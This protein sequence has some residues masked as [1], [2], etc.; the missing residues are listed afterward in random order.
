MTWPVIEVTRKRD[1]QS[2]RRH[3]LS[4]LGL[5]QRQPFGR[6][7]SG[8]ARAF[9]H[10]GYV[11]IDSISVVERAHHHVLHSRVPGFEPMMID[12][13][14]QRGEIFEYWSHAAAFLPMADFRFSLPYKDAIKRGQV[15][16]NRNPDIR[17]MNELLA[18]I[19]TDGPLKS[20]DLDNPTS[21][22]EGWWDW[23]P[24]K[25]ALEQLY[26]QG[27]LM[28]SDREGFQKTYDLAERVLP[29]GVDCSMPGL[30]AQAEYL[31]AQQLR[32][33][34]FVTLK[35]VT[36]LRKGAPLRAAVNAL[37]DEKLAA[38][39]LERVRI[40]GDVF[41]CEAGL[42]QRPMPRA[43]DR[44]T[45]LSPFD[46]G[47]IQ[48]ERLDA[49]FGFQYQLECYLPAARRRFGYFSLPLLYRDQFVGR[50]DCKVHRNAGRLEIRTL[51]FEPHGYDDEALLAALCESLETFMAFQGCDTVTIGRV[52]PVSA[53]ERVRSTLQRR[54]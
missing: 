22:R 5:L 36:Y 29:G 23:K 40:D 12:R 35:G 24:A 42:L 4:A 31:L 47:V 28:V 7:L 32:S 27:D 16:W 15:H 13:L 53:T 10:L 18:R 49:L 30:E 2:V 44:L 45:I 9:G 8:A 25:K 17:L 3:A 50:M 38:G 48:R 26:M 39:E 6:G 34:A 14:L 52:E 41:L 20:R 1:R 46:H 21:R 54:F 37:V 43:A 51:H 19:R 11:Q 33:H